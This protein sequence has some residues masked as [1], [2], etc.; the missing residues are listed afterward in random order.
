[1]PPRS[2]FH[3]SSTQP[4]WR[5]CALTASKRLRQSSTPWNS[6]KLMRHCASPRSLPH[7]STCAVGAMMCNV[8]LTGAACGSISRHGL[9]LV[10][11]PWQLRKHWERCSFPG[12]TCFEM[13]DSLFLLQGGGIIFKNKEP[14]AEKLVL[15]YME[16]VSSTCFDLRFIKIWPTLWFA[17]WFFDSV[18]V[19]HCST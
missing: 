10:S 19:A 1:M 11:C 15:K 7:D 12:L 17:V 16:K 3:Q 8:K 4:E 5:S 14:V 2:T 9:H 6:G 18:C 13:V